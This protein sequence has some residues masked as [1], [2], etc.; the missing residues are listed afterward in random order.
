M[1]SNLQTALKDQ[2][3]KKNQFNQKNCNLAF[4]LPHV[5][6]NLFDFLLQ[7]TEDI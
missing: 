4:L 1:F 3:K 7:N 6:S 5:I 2:K